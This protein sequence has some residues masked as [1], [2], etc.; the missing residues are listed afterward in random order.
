MTRS[1]SVALACALAL[2][3]TS[4]LAASQSSASITGLTFTL[5]DLKP[6]DGVAASFS[7]L[8]ANGSTALSVSASDTLVGDSDTQSRTRAGTFAFSREF[9]T[10]IANAGAKASITGQ[11]SLVASGSAAGP[12][13]SYNASVSTGVQNSYYYPSQLNLSLS[14]NTVLLITA[15]VSLTASASNPIGCSYYY[16]NVTESASSFASLTLAYSYN[17]S[18][19]S[20]SYSGTD[21]LSLQASAR[22]AYTES[23]YD[24]SHYNPYT[25]WYDYVTTVHPKVEEDKSLNDQLSQVFT[26]ASKSTQWASVGLSVGASGQANS[27]LAPTISINTP[28]MVPE[29]ESYAMGLA[30]LGVAG[31]LLRRRRRQG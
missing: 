3:A 7:F 23:Y 20:T 24:Y 9:L 19:L 13:T 2:S 10:D 8:N 31:L 12:Q 30:G 26:N 11:S 1:T 14:A 21:S 4:A 6:N 5:I 16:C 17:A 22:G 15:D 18:G 28:T 29:P 27:P 25:G